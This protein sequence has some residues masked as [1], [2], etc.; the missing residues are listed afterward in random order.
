MAPR[1]YVVLQHGVRLDRVVGAYDRWLKRVPG[2]YRRSVLESSGDGA[3]TAA[4]DPMCLG[5]LKHYHSLVPMGQEARKP[6]F[7]LRSADGAIGAHQQAVQ[8]AYG[9]FQTLANR[10]TDLVLDGAAM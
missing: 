5:L 6:V 3:P 8:S 10:I 4:D 7:L 1:G 9:R 2:E